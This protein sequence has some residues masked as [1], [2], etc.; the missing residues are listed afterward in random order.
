MRRTSDVP[1]KKNTLVNNG[2]IK[3]ITNN[4]NQN[5]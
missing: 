5:A 1:G 2:D 3:G 4:F